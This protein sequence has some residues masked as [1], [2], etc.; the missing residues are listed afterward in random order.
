M[1]THGGQGRMAHDRTAI[2]MDSS[3]CCR[4]KMTNVDA[5]ILIG[6]KLPMLVCVVLALWEIGKEGVGRE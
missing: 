4:W 6:I 1:F 2:P 3:V 5:A